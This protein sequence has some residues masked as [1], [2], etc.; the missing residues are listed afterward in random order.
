MK[1]LQC[2]K[3]IPEGKK[4]CNSSCAA[5]YNNAKRN[6]KPW[7]EEQRIAFSNR[8]K[9][10]NDLKRVERGR[11]R[12][13]LNTEEKFSKS[14][15]PKIEAACKYCGKPS[16]KYRVC[17]ECRP[18]IQNRAAFK[19]VGI[20]EEGSLSE[21]FRVFIDI[22]KVKYFEENLGLSGMS[23]ELGLNQTTIREAF[24]KA[25]IPLRSIGEGTRVAIEEGRLDPGS[26][27]RF[28]TG[29]HI[30]WQGYECKYRSSWELKFMEELDAKKVP[31]IFEFKWIK[32][33]NSENK[34]EQLALPDFYLPETNEIIELKSE[35]SIYG[36][37]QELKDKFRAYK[38]LGY[39][40]KLLL[41]WKY[42]D[43]EEL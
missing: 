22:L 2:G 25:G 26:S 42:V 23:Q 8:L 14:R 40:P 11:E 33:W 16:G 34:R 15:V 43:L 5:K 28:H 12:R 6:R 29:V 37:V 21:R 24:K 36:K 1:C 38:D 39:K 30:S 3:E 7:T 19:K 35:Y 27:R 10:G 17:D 9:L 32:Y 4:F 41:D 18:Y 13:Y 31:Y 20:P